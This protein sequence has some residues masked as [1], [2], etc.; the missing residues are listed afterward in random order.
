M[1]AY[2]PE[3]VCSETT[4]PLLSTSDFSAET[5]LPC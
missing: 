1:D 3:I 5:L 2:L 4:F